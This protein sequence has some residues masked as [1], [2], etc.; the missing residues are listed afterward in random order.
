MAVLPAGRFSGSLLLN[1][2]MSKH[3]TW[4]VG[5]PAEHYFVPADEQD[6]SLYLSTMDKHEAVFWLGLG[7]N[8]LVRDGGIKGSVIATANALTGIEL[9]SET[10]VEA[11]A[12]V[13]CAILA[14]FC[15]RNHLTGGEFFAGIPGVI[16]GALRMNAGAF[17]SE[18]WP[19]VE[20]VKTIS[21]DGTMQWRGAD[22]YQTAYRHVEG[23]EG[24]WFIRARFN[25]E[26]GDGTA[27]AE[28]IKKLL[29]KRAATQPTGTANCGSVFRNPENNFAA[30][31]IE[32]S[33]LK[34]YR[35][36]G[37]CVSEKHANFIINDQH[38]KAADIENLI[39]YVQ[40]QVFEK[41]GIKLQTEVHVVGES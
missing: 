41:T 24:E 9:I 32:E 25:F 39:G 15:A 6:L 2:P 40:Q 19:L 11:G 21:R 26:P 31:L 1:E 10:T 8:L 18:T 38:A 20:G 23:P 5:G 3:T 17:G 12:G 27:A 37:A 29:A 4:R 14:R 28:N 13:P 7:S 22:E 30:Q 34:G 35:I 36:G 16:G 33:G